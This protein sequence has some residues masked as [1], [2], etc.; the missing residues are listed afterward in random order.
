[1]QIIHFAADWRLLLRKR[2]V[3]A[4]HLHSKWKVVLG[5]GTAHY[6]FSVVYTKI[7][8]MPSFD[9]ILLWKFFS[10][11]FLSIGRE[12]AAMQ[13]DISSDYY[14]LYFKVHFSIE[15]FPKEAAATL[16]SCLAYSI[17]KWLL[18]S[19]ILRFEVLSRDY[20]KCRLLAVLTPP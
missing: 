10:F 20:S 14:L 17:R 8:K 15:A 18:V 6:F 3:E 7:K 16:K 4:N 11:L 13:N 1:M 5:G 2:R 9:I 12:E 19:F